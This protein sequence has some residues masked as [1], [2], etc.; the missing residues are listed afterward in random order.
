[1]AAPEAAAA[2]AAVTVAAVKPGTKKSTMSSN[3]LVSRVELF[4][5]NAA[6]GISL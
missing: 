6:A 1:V 3:T 4:D 2:A 5:G